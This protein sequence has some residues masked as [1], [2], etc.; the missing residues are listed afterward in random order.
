L[1]SRLQKLAAPVIER[2]RERARLDPANRVAESLPRYND[3]GVLLDKFF[4][5]KGIL[6]GLSA[7]FGSNV[8]FTGYSLEYSH[9]GQRWWQNCYA[10]A[11]LPTSDTA[12]MHYDHG[13]RNPKA[14]VALSEVSPENGPT[15]YILGS[16]KEPR[17]NFVHFLIKSI[18]L[19]FYDDY[20]KPD[21]GSTYYRPRFQRE[22]YRREFLMLPRALQACSHFGEDI[23]NDLPLSQDLLKNEIRLTKDV[24]DCITFDGDYGIHRGALCRSGERLV[25]QVIFTIQ[26]DPPRSVAIKNRLRAI[27]RKWIKGE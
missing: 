7:F 17:S 27:A 15:G 2:L 5:E 4:R 12:Y 3:I 22:E 19:R 1:K 6:Q 10:E 13:C 20:L 24:G 26:P 14:I 16:H 8:V 18:D 25:F 21:D 11:G 9:S 23:Q